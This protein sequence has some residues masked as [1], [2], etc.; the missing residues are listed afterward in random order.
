MVNDVFAV[1][2]ARTKPDLHVV[3]RKMIHNTMTN[4]TKSTNTAR[5]ITPKTEHTARE[6]TLSKPH[7]HNNISHKHTLPTQ[8]S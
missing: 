3:S 2:M 8:A 5:I 7:K 1:D 6:R 4:T